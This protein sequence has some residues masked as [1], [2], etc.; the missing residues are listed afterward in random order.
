MITI[1]KHSGSNQVD[2]SSSILPHFSKFSTQI[3]L[4]QSSFNSSSLRY[5]LPKKTCSLAP[6]EEKKKPL[7]ICG[8]SYV[9]HP[10]VQH[11]SS[12]TISSLVTRVQCQP[13]TRPNV[14]CFAFRTGQKWTRI[15]NKNLFGN[16]KKRQPV[17]LSCQEIQFYVTFSVFQKGHLRITQLPSTPPKTTH[18]N[19]ASHPAQ[20]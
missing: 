13:S 12:I 14:H 5:F 3:H 1:W 8:P 16:M 6:P 10:I 20:G 19:R 9:V 15:A 11:W 4:L 17:L 2:S 7:R 18:I